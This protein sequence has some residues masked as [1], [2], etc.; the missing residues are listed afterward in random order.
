MLHRGVNHVF[1]IAQL[2]QEPLADVNNWST[3]EFHSL[4]VF[5][6]LISFGSIQICSTFLEGFD[7]QTIRYWHSK[8]VNSVV[9]LKWWLNIKRLLLKL[10]KCVYFLYRYICMDK[11]LC[12]LKCILILRRCPPV[13][14]TSIFDLLIF[15]LC[16]PICLP[17]T[18]VKD[19]FRSVMLMYNSNLLIILSICNQRR[20]FALLIVICG[21]KTSVIYCSRNVFPICISYSDFFRGRILWLRLNPRF[22][23]LPQYMFHAISPSYIGF[24]TNMT[25]VWSW[26]I[27]DEGY[28]GYPL[29]AI[30]WIGLQCE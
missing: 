2:F 24:T 20:I 23:V 21:W 28:C 8:I 29:T 7:W 22:W 11:P 15:D 14:H 13:R 17:S 6:A 16:W 10:H 19:I 27:L 5:G 1:L 25:F 26:M 9:W 12:Q 30:W 3:V 4:A 18:F